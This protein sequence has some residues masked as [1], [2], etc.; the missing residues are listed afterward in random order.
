MGLAVDVA[1]EVLRGP[2]HLEQRL[3]EVAAL[4]RV[5]DH[6]VRVDPGPEQ[7]EDLLLAQHLLQHR[8]VQRDHD[9]AVDRGVRQLQAPVATHRVDDV[10]EQRLR[11]GV[12]GEAHEGVD[13]LLG[14]V[15][16]GP[17]VPQRQRGDAVGVDVLGRTLQ[18]GERSDRHARGL[19]VGVVDLQQQR[20]VRLDD[21]R[22]VGHAVS[23]PGARCG[24][25]VHDDK[26]QRP[27]A[28]LRRHCPKSARVLPRSYRFPMA[29]ARPPAGA[30]RALRAAPDRR[31]TGFPRCPRT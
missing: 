11:Y 16:R 26:A 12:A 7:R 15:T 17:R 18:L 14:V 2:A 13:H 27:T 22:P 21:Q 5:D 19:R 4:G 25:G 24:A 9:Q 20:L 28:I 30:C 29:I 1:R 3:L 10:D 23:L 6:R 8:P 31:R